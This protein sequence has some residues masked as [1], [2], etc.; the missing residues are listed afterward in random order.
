[1]ETVYT[2][3]RHQMNHTRTLGDMDSTKAEIVQHLPGLIALTKQA[4][5]N[6]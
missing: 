6:P 5:E 4:I 2:R 3:L 1:M